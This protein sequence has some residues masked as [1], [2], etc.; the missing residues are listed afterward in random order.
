MLRDK[1]SGLTQE[2]DTV[3]RERA[4]CQTV[5]IEQMEAENRRMRMDLSDKER[6]YSRLNE[7]MK[8]MLNERDSTLNKQKNEWADIYGNMKR[9][10][11]DLKR[12]VRLLI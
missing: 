8:G 11:D 2:L 3:S 9:E 1:V 6:E 12:D 4:N 10:S 7:Q 5:A